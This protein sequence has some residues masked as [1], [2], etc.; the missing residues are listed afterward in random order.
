M[1]SSC[2]AASSGRAC[3]KRGRGGWSRREI[4][5][6]TAVATCA[7]DFR[8]VEKVRG[9]KANMAGGEMVKKELGVMVVRCTCLKARRARALSTRT[10]KYAH[11]EV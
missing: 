11:A 10:M 5:R 2:F 6:S 1:R 9:R 7:Y 3:P 8:Y 4:T